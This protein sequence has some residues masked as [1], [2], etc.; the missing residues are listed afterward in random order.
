MLYIPKPIAQ[1]TSHRP[2][3]LAN[4]CLF[5]V[6]T[7]KMVEGSSRKKKM[8][9]D[10]VSHAKPRVKPVNIAVSSL[11]VCAVNTPRNKLHTPNI[12]NKLSAKAILSKKTEKGETAQSKDAKRAAFL[13]LDSW[14]ARRKTA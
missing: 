8:A 2:M 3:S 4:Q 12:V 6:S 1:E 11:R 13:S 5:F 9:G 7:R 10:L 14:L